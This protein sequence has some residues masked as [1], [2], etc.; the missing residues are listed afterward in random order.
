MARS[1]ERKERT[2]KD[3]GEKIKAAVWSV[4]DSVNE[5][6]AYMTSEEKMR[7]GRQ[8]MSIYMKDIEGNHDGAAQ[9]E[10]SGGL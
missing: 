10:G 1:E 4:H 5:C 9:G 2:G 8:L 7:W 3:K 6:G